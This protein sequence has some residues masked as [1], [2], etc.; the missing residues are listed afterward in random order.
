MTANDD[1]SLREEIEGEFEEQ[2]EGVEKLIETLM[3]SF[4]RSSSDYG[5]IADIETDIDPIYLLVKE[6]IEEKK[7]D[8]YALKIDDR[9][10]LSRTNEGFDDLYEVIKQH[11]ELQIKKDM[12]EIWDDAKNKILHL[13]VIPV[14]KHFPIK[15]KSPKQK[16]ETIKKI[17]L[18]T[19]S[20][21]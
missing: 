5:A 6:Y 4:L 16:M 18:M 19:W 8:V 12:I 10:L 11:S 7:M 9:I 15:Y 1:S 21:D 20:V 14:R 2:K 3:E 17:S 13:L